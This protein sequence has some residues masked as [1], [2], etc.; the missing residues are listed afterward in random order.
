ML[1]SFYYLQRRSRIVAKREEKYAEFNSVFVVV[2]LVLLALSTTV[3]AQEKFE[4]VMVAKHEGIS[5]FDDMRTGVEEFG[6]I[7][8]MLLLP[9]CPRRRDPAK[10]VQMV[11]TSL[12]RC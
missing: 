11:K 8:R 1:I 6:R 5:W 2:M 12:P 3:L 10:Q 7:M 4:I 9:D